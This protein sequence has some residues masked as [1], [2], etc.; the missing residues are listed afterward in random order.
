MM[1]A[2]PEYTALY[3]EVFGQLRQ[4]EIA[5]DEALL[6]AE[7]E[8]D[9][10]LENAARL[11]DGRIVFRNQNGDVVTQYGESVDT[12]LAA[13][14]KWPPEAP[15]Y[16][17]YLEEREQIDALRRYQVEVLGDARDRLSDEN[18][19]LEK[20]E[21]EQMQQDIQSGLDKTAAKEI[22]ATPAPK[23]DYEST[24]DIGLPKLG[25]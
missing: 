9:V 16:Q 24:A 13:E 5:T 10:L 3:N 18:N 1:L 2:D 22:E 4:A 21:L 17:E 15:T 14:I 20:D 11:P 12:D 6:A 19:P 8:L 23:Q 25:G 7:Q